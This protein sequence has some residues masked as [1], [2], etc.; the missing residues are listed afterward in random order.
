MKKYLLIFL[1]IFVCSTANAKPYW[2]NATSL[3]GGGTGALDAINGQ[4]L[5][6][7]DKCIVVAASGQTW[8]YNLDSDSALARR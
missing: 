7:G 6:D 1:F 2:Y 5:A 4:N 8:I 3:T